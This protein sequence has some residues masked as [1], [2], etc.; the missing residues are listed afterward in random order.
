[1]KIQLLPE[2]KTDLL[3]GIEWFDKIAA[4][5]GERFEAEFYACLHRLKGQ[6]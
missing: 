4:G 1:M 5:L 2:M 3:D 6:S